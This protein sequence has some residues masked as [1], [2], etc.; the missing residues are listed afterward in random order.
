MDFSQI[1]QIKP[2]YLV[3]G[4]IIL[5]VIVLI[6]VF[7][8]LQTSTITSAN[9]TFWGFEN[10]EVYRDVLLNI[11]AKYPINVTYVK[12]SPENYEKE[13]LNAMA[14][15][16]GPDV[17]PIHNTWVPR[18][19]DKMA[20]APA[21]LIPM[22]Q[23][24]DTFVDVATQDFVSEGYI[25]AAPLY[26]D[27]LALYWNKDLLNTA[28]IPEPPKTWD[29]FLEDVEKITKRD[30]AGNI[31][32]SGVAMGTGANVENA[33][34][35]L[36]LLMLQTGAKMV[37]DNKVRVNFNL[38][39][40]VSGREYKPG[41]AALEF[42]TDFANPQKKVYSWNV[43]MIN[44]KE[45]FLRGRAAMIFDYSAAADEILEES[46]YLNFSIAPAPQIKEAAVAV[47][48]ANYWANAVWSGSKVQKQ[49]WQFILYLAEKANAQEYAKKAKKPVA[50]RDLVSWQQN[51]QYLGVFATS[52]LSAR[53][54]YQV[55]NVSI[56]KIFEQTIE[57]VVTGQATISEAIERAANQVNIL[58]EEKSV[59]KAPMNVPSLPVGQ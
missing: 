17:F 3:S 30:D 22:K 26:V 40:V 32:L 25:W 18:F 59:N 16:Q 28:G 55:D 15:G 48:Y 42:Y 8:L 1:K 35:I 53:S 33:G 41:V 5:T 52:A 2:I 46:P 24:Y 58:M 49:A 6:L 36:S 20:P 43:K 39:T 51:D 23:Y 56:S 27:S 45:A 29:A 9:I 13:L 7:G 37:D 57:S 4:G 19:S 47:N 11:R 38:G 12:K 10:E 44:S 31:S 21:D 54:W 50:R 34:D 14:A